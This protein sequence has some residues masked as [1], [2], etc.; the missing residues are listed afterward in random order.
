MASYAYL[1]MAAYF[2]EQE[3]PGLAAWFRAHSREETDHAM[4]IFDFLALRSNRIELQGIEKPTMS[5]DTPSKAL[6]AALAMEKEVTALIHQLF[7]VAHEVKE[8][9]TQNMLHWFLEEQI[10]EEALF[11]RLLE[12]VNAAGDNNWQLLQFDRQVGAGLG[13]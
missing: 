7:E 1:A 10:K 2:E 4:R 12:Q 13:A 5:Y 6:E 3:L 8:Y 9:G 11:K